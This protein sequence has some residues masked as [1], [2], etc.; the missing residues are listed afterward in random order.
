MATAM[1]T[2]TW[3][4]PDGTFGSADDHNENVN[5]KKSMPKGLRVSRTQLTLDLERKHSE[6]HQQAPAQ[7]FFPMH[8][9]TIKDL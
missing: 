9:V 3:K 8:C 5:N 2:E 6:R 7:G 4:A 1:D